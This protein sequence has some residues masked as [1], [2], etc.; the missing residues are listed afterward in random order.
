M[1]YIKAHHKAAALNSTSQ[2]SQNGG[3]L[4]EVVHVVGIFLVKT[5][6]YS[7]SYTL[8]CF[9]LLVA[10]KSGLVSVVSRNRVDL[11]FSNVA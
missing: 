7:R 11:S 3:G 10:H 5:L 4:C 2:S 9:C 1:L 6:V 8:E